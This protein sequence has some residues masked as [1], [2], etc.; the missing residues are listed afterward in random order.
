MK[1][2]LFEKYGPPET[3]K[4]KEVDKPFP[5]KNELLIKVFAS[6]VNRTDCGIL[7]GKPFIIRFFTGLSK[8]KFSSTGTDFSGKIEEVGEEVKSFKVGDNVF[9]FAD[10][11]MNSHA[12]YMIISEDMPFFSM[13]ENI[14]FDQAAASLE[15]AHYAYNCIKRMKLNP[16]A[17]VLVYGAT[18]AIGSAAVQLLKNFDVYVTAVCN[19][20]NIDLVKSLG[21]DKIVD[22]TKEDFTKDDEIY[23][24]VFDAVGKSSFKKCKPLL[25]SGGAYMSTELGEYIQNPFLAIVTTFIGNKKVKFPIPLDTKGSIA[26][27]KKLLEA[28]KFKPVIDRKYK[29]EEIIE[30][31]NYV[32]SG[33]KTGNVVLEIN[34]HHQ[35]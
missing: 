19:T 34:S 11:G 16:G 30:A 23:D 15:G 32:E 2:I 18:G 7:R 25:K 10:Q 9:G 1:K 12:E 13:P 33:Q 24:C 21:P 4:I 29:F 26:F 27:I 17:K 20:K 31:F 14:N 35:Q 22:Y 5:K 28:N 6:T 3:L 8:P